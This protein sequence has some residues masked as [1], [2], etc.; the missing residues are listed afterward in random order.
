MQSS[1]WREPLDE[2]TTEDSGGH[3]RYVVPE[4]LLVDE[5]PTLFETLTILHQDRSA[6][7]TGNRHRVRGKHQREDQPIWHGE[8][9]HQK[10]AAGGGGIG[11]KKIAFATIAEQRNEIGH[12][13]V[14]RLYDPGEIKEQPSMAGARSVMGDLGS[15]SNP[16]RELLASRPASRCPMCRL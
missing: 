10:K 11:D 12:K 9:G 14:K 4:P 16:P 2:L 8:L 6:Q 5:R 1:R 3:R 13:A 15:L 7:S